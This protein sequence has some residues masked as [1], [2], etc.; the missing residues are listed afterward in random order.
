M[1]ISRPRRPE[2]PA[3]R[4]LASGTGCAPRDCFF[5]ARRTLFFRYV[6]Y[7]TSHAC[8]AL[9]GCNHSPRVT[10][11]EQKRLPFSLSAPDATHSHRTMVRSGKEPA[12]PDDASTQLSWQEVRRLNGINRQLRPDSAAQRLAASQAAAAKR[13]ADAMPADERK[14]K[15]AQ[16]MKEVRARQRAERAAAASAQSGSTQSNAATATMPSE[17]TAIE[18]AAAE[19][20]ATESAAAKPDLALFNGWLRCEGYGPI[21]E[22]EWDEFNDDG[23]FDDAPR[24]AIFTN[25]TVVRVCGVT[26]SA[27]LCAGVID[28]NMEVVALSLNIF[29]ITST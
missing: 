22:D 10:S 7:R 2:A 13:R 12:A 26:H 5:A 28:A 29:S 4:A 18:S 9:S 3:R 27:G 19:P 15:R 20:A 23:A 8:P 1:Q 11:T 24:L 16:H 14:A 6:R 17:P 25:V 21:E